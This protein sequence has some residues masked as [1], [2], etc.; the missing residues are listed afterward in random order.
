SVLVTV[1]A[2]TIVLFTSS[3]VGFVFAKYEFRFKNLV[4]WLIL[5]TMMVPPQTTMIPSFLL[6]N[7][8]GL[9][10]KLP[11]L[12]VPGMVGGF[13]IFLCRQ[14]ISDVPDSL[15]EA[16]SIDG[17]NAWQTFT[18]IIFPMLKPTHTIVVGMAIV[19]SFKTFD[20][21][22]V[23]T[24][25][26]PARTSETLAVTMYI[27]TFSKLKMGYGAAIAVLLSLIILPIAV[28]YIRQMIY[29]DAIDYK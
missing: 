23:M 17:A 7:K 13:G 29:N 28:V 8:L 18:H 5:A 25:G 9:Y 22:F 27:E 15:C 24:R 1:T 3:L 19:N 20:L 21:I 26:G 16:A 6:I 12:I 11:S 4:F 2:T 14:F 10:D